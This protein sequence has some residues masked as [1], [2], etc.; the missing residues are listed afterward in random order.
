MTISIAVMNT[1]LTSYEYMFALLTTA[2]GEL[3][4]IY[5]ILISIFSEII[6]VFSHILSQSLYTQVTSLL[7]S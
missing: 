7:L 3:Q 6:L 1:C 5:V 2:K 4:I